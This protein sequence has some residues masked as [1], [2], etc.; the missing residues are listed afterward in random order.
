MMKKTILTFGAISGAVSSAMMLL[1]LPLLDRIGFDNGAVIGYTGIVASFLPVFFGIRAYREQ[2]GGALTFG[3]A[4]SVGLLITLISCACYVATWEVIYFK[5]RPGFAD[6]FASHAIEKVR[7][8]G[9]TPQAIEDT[10]RQM[11]DFKK[12]YDNPVINA[13]M[14]FVEPFPIGLVVTLISAG[15]LR[16]RA[17]HAPSR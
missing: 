9:G 11:A 4:C 3:R 1:T 7:A 6:E 15:A 16:R 8:S 13:G 5:I 12:L 17:P 2:Q 14:T 10:R